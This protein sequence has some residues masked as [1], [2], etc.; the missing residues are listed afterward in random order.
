M[1]SS[2]M[3]VDYDVLQ[4]GVSA[5]GTWTAMER[6]SATRPTRVDHS[7]MWT[8]NHDYDHDHDQVF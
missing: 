1:K 4:K 3:N 7:A 2:V 8:G 5:T 6:E